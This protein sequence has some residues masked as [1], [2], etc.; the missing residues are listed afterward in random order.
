MNKFDLINKVLVS[1][2][3]EDDKLLL[4]ELI[5]RTNHE[6]QGTW[7][8][9][10]SV[11]RLCQVRGIKYEKNFKGADFY[12]PGLV[13]KRKSCRK[14]VYTVDVDAIMALPAFEVTIKHTPAVEGANTP[15]LADNAPAVAENTPAVEGANSTSNN[16]K[17]S[18]EDSTSALAVASA[19]AST[20]IPSRS[21]NT[22]EDQ[23]TPLSTYNTG[24]V[25]DAPSLSLSPNDTGRI[26]G[27]TPAT[28]GPIREKKLMTEELRTDIRAAAERKK[29]DEW[30]DDDRPIWDEACTLALDETFRPDLRFASVRVTRAKQHLEG[31]RL[32]AAVPA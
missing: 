24:S 19:P 2:L 17:N 26:A 13:T 3:Q 6:Q 18:T 10:P 21:K 30:L 5:V 29:D 15:A 23:P 12:L 22:K 7:D 8:C 28:G 4:L 20:P 16:T 31:R 27:G 32:R 14:N 1:T 11:Q 25:A 9:W